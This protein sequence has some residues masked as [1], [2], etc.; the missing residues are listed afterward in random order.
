MKKI[1]EADL[2]ITKWEDI[3]RKTKEL[4][5]LIDNFDGS[6]LEAAAY[7]CFEVIV[8]ASHNQF[9]AMGILAETLLSYRET[10]LEILA[11]EDKNEGK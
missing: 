5:E 11:E 8:W 2:A 10:S 3:E 1:K 7:V 9:E 6:K 4:T